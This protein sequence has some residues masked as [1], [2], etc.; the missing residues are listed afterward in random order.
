MTVLL[1]DMHKHSPVVKLKEVTLA[2]VSVAKPVSGKIEW[3]SWKVMPREEKTFP[4]SCLMEPLKCPRPSRCRWGARVE[5]QSGPS[6]F[7][8]LLI[9]HPWLNG[10]PRSA[11]ARISTWDQAAHTLPNHTLHTGF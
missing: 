11:D 1:S 2:D 9:A 3:Q 5:R 10:P 8:C 7:C 4:T 6:T